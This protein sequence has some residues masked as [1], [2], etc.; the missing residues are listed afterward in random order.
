[1]ADRPHSISLFLS[2]LAMMIAGLSWWESHSARVANES[3]NRAIAYITD[4]Q[5]LPPSESGQYLYKLTIK[6]FGRSTALV[7]GYKLSVVVDKTE[8]AMQDYREKEIKEI[9]YSL[10]PGVEKQTVF[11]IPW[12]KIPG[13]QDGEFRFIYIDVGYLDEPSM[14]EYQELLCYKVQ[15]DGKLS[16]CEHFN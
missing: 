2:I 6:N 1:M 8:Q 9:T 10:P 5:S 13:P 15:A 16:R 11:D 12:A 7:P 14:K 4:F 3:S